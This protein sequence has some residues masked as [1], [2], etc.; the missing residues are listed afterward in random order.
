MEVEYSL[1]LEDLLAF[2]DY[3]NAH[4][5]T[6]GR[7]Q[8][9][10]RLAVPI[11]LAGLW[12]LLS[13]IVGGFVGPS[14]WII[15]GLLIGLVGAVFVFSYPALLRRRIRR[16]VQRLYMEGQNRGLFT[17]RRMTI[18]PETVT[19]ATEV[20]VTTMKWVA[21]ERIV[22]DQR[23]A[24]FYTSAASAFILPK[25]AFET[26]EEFQEFVETAQGYQREAPG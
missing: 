9:T 1:E 6:F 20:S 24:F 7:Q 26:E 5:P 2:N 12:V 13:G 22:V 10:V 4:S 15:L 18:T 8:L 14:V 25:A 3:R 17:R 11:M 19:D 21:V 16:L 23:H